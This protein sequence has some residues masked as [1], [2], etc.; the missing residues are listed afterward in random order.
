MCPVRRRRHGVCRLPTTWRSTSPERQPAQQ[1]DRGS[2]V[3]ERGCRLSER[4]RTEALKA[5]TSQS[6]N[7]GVPASRPEVVTKPSTT[8]VTSHPV[9][10]TTSSMANGSAS[11]ST[12]SGYQPVS[13]L[14][15]QNS[16]VSKIYF[17]TDC[18]IDAGS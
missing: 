13:C 11:S 2:R 6:D 3:P 8:N 1:Q 14:S 15:P 5:L 10:T 16:K 7:G 17:Q 12:V 4:G 9:K 18:R